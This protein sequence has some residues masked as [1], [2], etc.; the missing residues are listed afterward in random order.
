[1]KSLFVAFIL[2]F[3]SA[4]AQAQFQT[5]SVENS[6]IINADIETVF[7]FAA[8]PVND[9]QWR[10]EVNAMSATGPWEVGT[11]YYEDSRLGFNPHYITPTIL[12][13]LDPTYTM[14]VETPEDNLYLQAKRTFEELA[15]GS[16]RMTYRLEVDVRMPSDAAGFYVPPLLA[17]IYYDNVMSGYL[18]RLKS[19]LENE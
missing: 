1:M 4:T 7:N 3:G 2:F 15:D 5:F 17:K 12:I 14:L 6:I 16:T 8:N 18:W 10:S 19:I 9:S 11:I 13:E